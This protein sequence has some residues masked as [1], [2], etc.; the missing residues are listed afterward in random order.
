MNDLRCSWDTR[1]R[2]LPETDL[3][4]G[5]QL[6]FCLKGRKVAADGKAN[7]LTK[8]RR[9]PDTAVKDIDSPGGSWKFNTGKTEHMLLIS[10]FA[11]LSIS[12]QSEEAQKQLPLIPV[13]KEQS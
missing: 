9:S 7:M 3:L 12:W 10:G 5:W 1:P 13:H 2:G 8:S 4:V 6:P 11:W